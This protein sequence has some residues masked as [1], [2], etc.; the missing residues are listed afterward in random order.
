MFLPTPEIQFE[1]NNPDEQNPAESVHN[2]GNPAQVTRP[3]SSRRSATLRTQSAGSQGNSQRLKNWFV[4]SDGENR[5]FRNEKPR[6]PERTSQ[7]DED[8]GRNNAQESDDQSSPLI[9]ETTSSSDDHGSATS[10]TVRETCQQQEEGV[11][12][13]DPAFYNLEVRLEY[14]DSLSAWRF[15]AVFT[16]ISVHS[17][18]SILLRDLFVG[19]ET[20]SSPFPCVAFGIDSASCFQP[21]SHRGAPATTRLF[22]PIPFFSHVTKPRDVL[23]SLERNAAITHA[24][25]GVAVRPLRAYL[26][27][28]DRSRLSRRDRHVRSFH[29]SDANSLQQQQQKVQIQ[30]DSF[31][32]TIAADPPDRRASTPLPPSTPPHHSSTRNRTPVDHK[33]SPR[34]LTQKAKKTSARPQMKSAIPRKEALGL[35]YHHHNDEGDSDCSPWDNGSDHTA[36]VAL[37]VTASTCPRATSPQKSQRPT[38]SPSPRASPD[39]TRT[40]ASPSPR[41]PP[42][43][44]Q[45]GALSTETKKQQLRAAMQVRLLFVCIHPHALLLT[46]PSSHSQRELQSEKQRLVS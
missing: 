19:D 43:S 38:H 44:L 24:V 8:V 18:P 20:M 46:P 5:A 11:A 25:I 16:D 14:P 1:I 26:G 21:P 33:H 41:K 37:L 27:I 2:T 30:N 3:H 28:V 15:Q 39:A 6:S 23:C 29:G 35:H 4:P 9:P 13:D 17:R 7:H 12:I 42:Q 45:A 22:N 40:S 34:S 32:D 10:D 31:V 36:S